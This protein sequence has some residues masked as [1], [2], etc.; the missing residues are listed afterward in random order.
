MYLGAD[1]RKQEWR[2]GK[3]E[4]MKG[5]TGKVNTTMGK[6]D[7]I[8][9]RTFWG[10]VFVGISDLSLQRMVCGSSHPIYLTLTVYGLPWGWLQGAFHLG[11]HSFRESL[12]AVPFPSRENSGSV[13]STK[14]PVSILHS[15]PRGPQSLAPQLPSL[16]QFTVFSFK[17]F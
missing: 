7:P 4:K 17:I 14:R 10:I 9:L 3:S 2:N 5:K 6:E 11:S 16:P 12:E 13:W 8:I 1:A 15:P